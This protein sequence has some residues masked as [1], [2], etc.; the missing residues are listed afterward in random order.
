MDSKTKSDRLIPN[1]K[2]DIIICENENG[3]SLVSCNFRG[4]K[5]DQKRA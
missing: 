4:Y 5:C 2:L 1:N 3:S